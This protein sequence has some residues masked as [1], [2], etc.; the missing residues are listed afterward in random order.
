M[1]S[2]TV[3]GSTPP[4]RPPR[5]R[6]ALCNEVLAPFDLVRQCHFARQLGFDGLEIAPFTLS[7]EPHRIS[8]AEALD[9]RRTVTEHGLVVTGLHW[10]MVAPAGLSI[11][12]PDASRRQAAR[13]VLLHLLDLCEALGGTVMVHGSPRQRSPEPGQTS[14]AC[15]AHMKEIFAYLAPEAGA[16]GITYCIEPLS[17]AETPVI[18]TVEEAAA[19]V[20][21]VDH[22]A[23]RTMIDTS[24]A[25]LAETQPI[26]DLI[27][28]WMP[29]GLI[30]HIQV[31]DPN[32]RG[33]GEGDL[34]F[35]PIIEALAD[36][37]YAGT[38]AAEPF[39]YTPDGPTCASRIA[40]YMQ[41]VM[42][43]SWR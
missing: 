31:N 1:S 25:S 5:P 41:G 13:D 2:R 4:G 35:G 24:A 38:I 15:L 3:A 37:G 21:A 22:P 33:P 39:I 28:Q 16:R 29:T 8:M 30:A 43:T 18:N 42:E 12:A 9:I 32:R 11:T 40:G 7:P 36:T 27:R 6:L 23:F 34:A 10:L 26:Q 19:L 20:R 17:R 14:E